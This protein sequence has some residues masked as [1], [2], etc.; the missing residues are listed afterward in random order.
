MDQ[1]FSCILHFRSH[2]QCPIIWSCL[3]Y[4]LVTST[5][6]ALFSLQN[7]RCKYSPMPSE[8]QF[9]EP[10][11]TLGISK[12]HPSWCMDIFWNYPL[13]LKKKWKFRRGLFTIPSGMEIP[14]GWVKM[15]ISVAGEVWTFSGSTQSIHSI[16]QPTTL[17]GYLQLY[18]KTNEQWNT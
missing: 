8:F 18:Q 2:H 15:K 17:V 16:N 4:E 12:S 14:R 7:S 1:C 13:S 10:P 6:L 5:K 11:L 3:I 9:K